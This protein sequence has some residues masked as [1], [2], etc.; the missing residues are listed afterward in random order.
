MFVL[1]VY[2]ID[3]NCDD[4]PSRLRKIASICENYG[5]RVQNSVFE[6]ELNAGKLKELKMRLEIVM[7][8]QYDSIRLYKIKNKNPNDIEVLGKLNKVECLK[9][10]TYIL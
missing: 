3:F 4:G 8:R 5:V 1:L 6:M 9:D 7:D 2:D 10:N